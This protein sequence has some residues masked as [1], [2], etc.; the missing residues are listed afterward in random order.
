MLTIQ[1]L[2]L[3]FPTIKRK[4]FVALTHHQSKLLKIKKRKW[5]KDKV[6]APSSVCTIPR[7][8]CPMHPLISNYTDLA[9]NDFS[10]IKKHKL[11][12]VTTLVAVPV[13]SFIMNLDSN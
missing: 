12:F 10:R 5:T 7:S 6:N 13:S 9:T 11:N 8:P 1:S 4:S 2:S 3:Y